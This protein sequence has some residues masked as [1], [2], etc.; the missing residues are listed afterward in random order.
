MLGL[1]LKEN[2]RFLAN[3]SCMTEVGEFIDLC[4]NFLPLEVAE[5]VKSIEDL[6]IIKLKY[7]GK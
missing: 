6:I 5:K 7:D 2:N 4:D 1:Y 3:V